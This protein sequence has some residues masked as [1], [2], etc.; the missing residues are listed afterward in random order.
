MTL[1]SCKA[2]RMAFTVFGFFP[3][4]SSVKAQTFS[5]WSFHMSCVVTEVKPSLS[6]IARTFQGSPT[7]KPSI[8]PMRM[9]ETICGGGIVMR[10]MS[11][12]GLMPPAPR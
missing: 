10:L 1:A 12:S 9:F 6:E 7:Q 5:G 11:L 2:F 8:L 3:A 4:N